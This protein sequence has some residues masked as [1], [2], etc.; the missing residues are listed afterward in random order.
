[1]DRK[2]FPS[3]LANS[4]LSN[5]VDL[6]NEWLNAGGDWEKVSLSYERK[7]AE[8]RKVKK[9]RKGMKARDIIA[10]YGEK[11]LG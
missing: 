11:S 1:M 5:K 4:F 3:N 8:R 6:F 7:T 9:Q 2:K 10:A